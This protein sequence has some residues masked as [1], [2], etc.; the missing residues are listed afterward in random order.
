[1]FFS[2]LRYL[3]TKFNDP[4]VIER[5][6][7]RL[8]VRAGSGGQ[9]LPR[10]NGVG[11]D[12]GDVY[13]LPRRKMS[14]GHFFNDFRDKIKIKAEHGASSTQINLIG[15]HGNHAVV[16]VPLGAE[17][18]DA[19]TNV[20]ICRCTVPNQKILI[21]KGGKGG[22]AANNYKGQVGESFVMNVHMKLHPNVGIIG[23]PNAGKSTLLK[24]LAPEKKSIK[25]APYPFT[26]T[27]PQVLD[28]RFGELY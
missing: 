10:Y 20:L 7:I 23:F 25:I 19:L 11:G 1:M 6:I 16:S 18:V 5:D 28:V 17:C 4:T 2:R 14:F 3:A 26:T 9:G 13:L 8:T 27:K 21:A 12:G 22:C 15:K 24:A